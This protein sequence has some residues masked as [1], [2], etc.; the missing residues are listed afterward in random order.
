M[1][2]YIY[3]CVCVCVCVCVCMYDIWVKKSIAILY[4][5]TFLTD[6]WKFILYSSY[7]NV[8]CDVY[9]VSSF[10]HIF[11]LGKKGLPPA[12]LYACIFLWNL[13]S[14]RKVSF[15]LMLLT[16]LLKANQ[17]SLWRLKK[18][19]KETSLFSERSSD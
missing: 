19:W 10:V 13:E 14:D 6:S 1:C 5:L 16:V 4:N 17:L 15:I 7:L 3:M 11:F 8:T 9:P 2:V 18:K 12:N